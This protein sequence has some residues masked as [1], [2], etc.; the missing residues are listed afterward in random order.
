MNLNYSVNLQYK[1]F[2]I[3]QQKRNGYDQ[4]I[5]LNVFSLIAHF[6]IHVGECQVWVTQL[7]DI[8]HCDVRKIRD[9]IQTL[10]KAGMIKEIRPYQR[11]TQ[12]A[13]VYQL[14]QAWCTRC[15]KLVH[16]K[17]KASA[18]AP[19][20]NNINNII[21]EDAAKASPPNKKK[22]PPTNMDDRETW[23]L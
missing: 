2:D 17:H 19:Q 14:H 8:W 16:Q 10:V 12:Q 3:F 20:V 23:E 11:K 18:P 1:E 22:R 15:K 7:S 5:L 21:R 13:A 9:A 4:I 6:S